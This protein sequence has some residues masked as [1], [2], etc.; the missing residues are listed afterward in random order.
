KGRRMTIMPTAAAMARG[1]PTSIAVRTQSMAVNLAVR[2]IQKPEDALLLAFVRKRSEVEA[3]E[4]RQAA[5]DDQLG[6]DGMLRRF[7][8]MRTAP[9]RPKIVL[10]DV[11]SQRGRGSD[12]SDITMSN[13]QASWTG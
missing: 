7:L 3:G 6:K 9:M 13:F 10:G 2:V 4:A 5:T 1:L 11:A 8:G 12:A